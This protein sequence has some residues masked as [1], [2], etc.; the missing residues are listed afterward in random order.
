MD[1]RLQTVV[2]FMNANLYRKLS[3][4]ELARSV[5]ISRSHLCFLFK[6]QLG[7]PPVQYLI[8]LRMQKAHE[9]LGTTLLGVKQIMAQVGY[10]DKS[11]FARHFTRAY[12]LTPAQYKAKHR[13]LVLIRDRLVRQNRNI[14]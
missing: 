4:Y 8:T 5:N 11:L 7:L 13:D 6:T 1:A 3:L 10:N 12:G 14:V 2:E 9:L